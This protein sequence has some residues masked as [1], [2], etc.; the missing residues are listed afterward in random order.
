MQI[1]FAN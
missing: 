1:G